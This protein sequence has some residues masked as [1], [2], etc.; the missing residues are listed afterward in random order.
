MGTQGVAFECDKMILMSLLEKHQGRVSH[1]ADELEIQRHTL[2]KYIKKD[3]EL[4]DFLDSVR[5]G[6]QHQLLDDAEATIYYAL[7]HK[8]ENLNAALRSAFFIL[9]NLGRDRGYDHPEV[10]VDDERKKELK[11]LFDRVDLLVNKPVDK[12]PQTTQEK[13]AQNPVQEPHNQMLRDT[14]PQFSVPVQPTPGPATA[15]TP[16]SVPTLEQS[17]ERKSVRFTSANTPFSQNT[18]ANIPPPQKRTHPVFPTHQF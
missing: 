11:D 13:Q 3:D 8:E 12:P 6:Y 7:E 18:Q 1:V 17:F 2:L 10:R 4:K 15:Q 9:T 5:K 14:P 16:P